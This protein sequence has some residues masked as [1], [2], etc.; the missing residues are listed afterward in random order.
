MTKVDDESNQQRGGNRPTERCPTNYHKRLSPI[1]EASV[2]AAEQELKKKAWSE[3]GPDHSEPT[4]PS[5]SPHAPEVDGGAD[6]K[7]RQRRKPYWTRNLHRMLDVRLPPNGSRLSCGR[8]A[9]GRKAVEP[10]I[11]RLAGEATQLFP[12]GER[13]AASSAC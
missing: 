1:A 12:T 4:G 8:N 2:T 10:Q 6:K 3:K 7:P 11:K 9:R 13:P 5:V